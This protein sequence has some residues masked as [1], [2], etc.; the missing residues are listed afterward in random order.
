MAVELTA[1]RAEEKFRGFTQFADHLMRDAV[2]DG[3]GMGADTMRSLVPVG[4]TGT[5]RNAVFSNT[6]TIAP[7]HYR[8]VTGVDPAVKQGVMVDQ[9][10]GIDGPK[11]S[12]VFPK[13]RLVM[14]FKSYYSTAK[15][16]SV[17]RPVV[18]FHPS[19]KIQ[20]SKG[21]QLKTFE[22][23]NVWTEVR[24]ASITGR[25]AAYFAAQ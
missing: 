16:Q 22:A 3:S 4:R 2:D 1:G 23:M 18:K 6:L 19:T 24:V 21:Y 13:T 14:K 12:P 8:G 5:L 17:Y 10:T 25:V 15:G 9:G 7:H 20:Q 11:N